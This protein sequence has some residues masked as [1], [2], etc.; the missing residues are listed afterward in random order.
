MTYNWR[1]DI[2]ASEK[3]SNRQDQY[4]LGTKFTTGFLG[5]LHLAWHVNIILYGRDIG[6]CPHGGSGCGGVILFLYRHLLA[7]ISW[8]TTQCSQPPYTL[9]NPKGALVSLRTWHQYL[10]DNGVL[11]NKS[12]FNC[13]RPNKHAYAKSKWAWYKCNITYSHSWQPLLGILISVSAVL[14]WI[15]HRF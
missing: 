14:F 3:I 11:C 12:H 13:S 9:P 6:T 10:R 15:E 8:S 7:K 5:F 1:G 4:K 2:Y